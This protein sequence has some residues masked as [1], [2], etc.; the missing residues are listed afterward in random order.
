MRFSKCI[1]ID[2]YVYS[3]CESQDATYYCII[4]LTAHFPSAS[5]K[6][7]SRL[8]NICNWI[9]R[10]LICYQMY[11]T[12]FWPNS[13]RKYN[14]TSI[15]VFICFFHK[16]LRSLLDVFSH[17]LNQLYLSLL[18]VCNDRIIWL[19]EMRQY[20]TLVVL[21]EKKHYEW[22]LVLRHSPDSKTEDIHT[23]NGTSH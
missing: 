16:M 22:N 4:A 5:F 11:L 13:Q 1:F 6:I 7:S 17:F 10:C 19:F 21:S 2:N 14:R 18:P 20:A 3:D 8:D 9:V 15:L 12:L 23:F